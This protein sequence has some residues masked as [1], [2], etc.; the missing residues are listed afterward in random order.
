MPDETLPPA[1]IKL[2]WLIGTLAAFVLF[3]AIGGYSARMTRD[4]TDYDQ[5]RAQVRYQT[6]AKLRATEG[7]LVNPVDAQGNSTAEWVDQDK[8]LIRIPIDEAMV[9]EVDT[10]KAQPAAQ[11]TAIDGTA[12]PPPTASTNAAPATTNAAPATNAP[13]P[14]PA[15]T[16]GVPST[17]AKAKKR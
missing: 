17:P 9:D 11:C 6:L 1:Q 4:Y 15:P 12:P 14:A 10:L 3:A 16:N 2:S 7:K 5:Q 8:G 13:A